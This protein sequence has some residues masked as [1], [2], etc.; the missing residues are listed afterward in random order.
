MS[1][2]KRL[3]ARSMPTANGGFRHC[4]GEDSETHTPEG[5]Q[6]TTQVHRFLAPNREDLSLPGFSLMR[7]S[8]ALHVAQCQCRRS[9]ASPRR[10]RG[11]KGGWPA[12]LTPKQVCT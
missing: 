3:D 8:P 9:P 11:R 1:R 12:K 5:E 6:A 2:L 4:E 7:P 10:A